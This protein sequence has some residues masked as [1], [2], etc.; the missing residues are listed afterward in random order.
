LSGRSGK[1]SLD[2]SADLGTRTACFLDVSVAR[3][4]LVKFVGGLRVRMTS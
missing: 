4:Q 3:D 1:V 2:L